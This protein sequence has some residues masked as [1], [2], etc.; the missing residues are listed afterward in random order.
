M[1]RLL[2]LVRSSRRQTGSLPITLRVMGNW[3]GSNK[4]NELHWSQDTAD[5]V[6]YRD[7]GKWWLSRSMDTDDE[8]RQQ[9]LGD[10]PVDQAVKQADQIL[11]TEFADYHEV[12]ETAE[13]RAGAKEAYAAWQADLQS[14]E[15]EQDYFDKMDRLDINLAE[16]GLERGE[17][18]DE[19]IPLRD[20]S[21]FGIGER[22]RNALR[23]RNEDGMIRIPWPRDKNG[24]YAVEVKQP[25][26]E[27][28]YLSAAGIRDEGP[29]LNKITEAAQ[30]ERRGEA[31]YFGH[32]TS[33]HVDGNIAI[34]RES[35]ALAY[36]Q[37]RQSHEDMRTVLN[38]ANEI[39]DRTPAE[40]EAIGRVTQ[41]LDWASDHSLNWSQDLGRGR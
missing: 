21:E 1:T 19:E 31:N 23:D 40:D 11:W 5:A 10:V 6:L 8:W 33:Q 24:P 4:E 28:Q 20:L 18:I 36:E 9:E 32:I 26:H 38:L 27:P 15:L 16:R 3:S 29:L 13:L 25:G 2:S 12:R 37:Q 41:S 30:F 14:E 7:D 22:I 34:V 35:E 39:E 17:D